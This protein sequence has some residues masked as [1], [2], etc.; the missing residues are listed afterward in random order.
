M[1]GSCD[2]KVVYTK[3]KNNYLIISW[4][5]YDLANQF[6]ALNIVSL[7]FPLWL[8]EA[9]KS[10]EIFYSLSF[11]ISMI[12]IAI[13]APLL[14]I[15]ADM[16]NKHKDFLIFLTLL[17]II[18]TMALGFT[19]N[20][21]VGLIFFAIANMGCQ[22]AV[23]FYNA[24]MVKVAP[25]EKIGFVSGIGRMFGYL[26]AILALLLTK[27]VVIK[28]GYQATFILTGVLF[29]IF[30]LPCMIFIKEREVKDNRNLRDFLNKNMLS[31]I[32][33]R[34]KSTIF[35]SYR[36]AELRVFL[37]AAFFGLCV[38]NAL[39]LFMSVYARNAFG[40]TEPQIINLIAFSTLFAILSSIFSGFISDIIGYKKSLLGVFAL[41]GISLF[42]AST[43]KP[44][45]HWL[46]GA[47]VG[48]SLGATWVISRALVVT[49]VPHGKIGEV[50]GLFN[51]V[52]YL[53]GI[54]GPLSW[55]MLVFFTSSLGPAGY[56][57]TCLSMI[58]FIVIG[59]IFLLKL[60]RQSERDGP[61]KPKRASG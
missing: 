19:G 35:D 47:L 40:L 15:I 18:F 9:K 56:R 38:V 46:I 28:I 7:Y 41:W 25:K 27:P 34:L 14:G 3:L 21:L 30:S 48:T 23:V 36:F 52:G 22:G 2:M 13:C 6:F 50:F 51:V 24:L 31:Q 44:P 33:S 37:K 10:P 11:G 61:E 26:G 39:M 53:S 32:V 60:G 1:Y 45:F 29:L 16:R 5:L 49:L 43:L 20:V 58:V 12:L 57:I 54:V 42:L 17:S 59:F 8:T 55:G 4:A